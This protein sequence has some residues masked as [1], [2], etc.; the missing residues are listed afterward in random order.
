MGRLAFRP[1]CSF[2]D[3]AKG[4]TLSEKIHYLLLSDKQPKWL[5]QHKSYPCD[6]NTKHSA[7]LADESP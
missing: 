4:R 1:Q 5:T 6:V 3:A 2:G 7:N